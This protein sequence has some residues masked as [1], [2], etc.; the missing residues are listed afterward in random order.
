[1]TKHFQFEQVSIVDFNF[2]I[3]EMEKVNTVFPIFWN[4]MNLWRNGEN[5]T[6]DIWLIQHLNMIVYVNFFHF[7]FFELLRSVVLCL[8]LILENYWMFFIQIFSSLQLSFPSSFIFQLH[9]YIW[10]PPMVLGFSNSCVFWWFHYF[11]SPQFYWPI[12]KLTGFFPWP[13]H[14][15]WWAHKRHFFHYCYYVFHFYHFQ[16]FFIVSFLL[17][18]ICNLSTWS[19]ESLILQLF[20]IPFLIISTCFISESGS[21]IFFFFWIQCWCLFFFFFLTLSMLPKYFFEKSQTSYIV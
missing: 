20:Q 16:M 4:L 14:I 3:S 11:L 18:S 5:I 8:L 13:C 10:Y 15:F 2:L 21:I 17:E 6:I 1:M 12:F 19:L 7:L 9:M